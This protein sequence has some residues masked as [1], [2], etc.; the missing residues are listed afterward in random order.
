MADA[1]IRV[2]IE[3]LQSTLE[4]IAQLDQAVASIGTGS[5]GAGSMPISSEGTVSAT[6]PNIGATAPPPAPSQHATTIS[7]AATTAGTHQM[8]ATAGSVHAD[9]IDANSANPIP[10]TPSPA[11]PSS[12]PMLPR[13]PLPGETF[14]EWTQA[15]PSRVPL[16]NIYHSPT[17]PIID[18]DYDPASGTY[19]MA[20]SF[21][22]NASTV[23]GGVSGGGGAGGG[24]VAS[25]A[26]GSS[27]SKP[28]GIFNTGPFG[29]KD[30]GEGNLMSFLW[31]SYMVQGMMGQ[32]GGAYAQS[33]VSGV[34]YQSVQEG[35][36]MIGLGITGAGALLTTAM[37]LGPLP[38]MLGG[39]MI[40]SIVSSVM[41]PGADRDAQLANLYEVMGRNG[42]TG[43]YQP[44][45]TLPMIQEGSKL[46]QAGMPLTSQQM[47]DL[48]GTD[49]RGFWSGADHAFLKYT[50]LQWL[51]GMSDKDVDKSEQSDA[52][53]RWMYGTTTKGLFDSQYA[54]QDTDTM[55]KAYYGQTSRDIQGGRLVRTHK[56][57]MNSGD[58][59]NTAMILA[60]TDPQSALGLLATDNSA[61]KGQIDAVTKKG[62][63][64][65][66]A[67]FTGQM[68]Q[69][70]T[71]DLMAQMHMASY[72][73][74][75]EMTKVAP[76]LLSE[77]NSQASA[78]RAL[79]NAV[80][81]PLLK[82]QY[83][84]QAHILEMTANEQVYGQIFQEKS[85]E[86]SAFG[87]LNIDK[88]NISLQEQLHSGK[89]AY[90]TNWSAVSG[91]YEKQAGDTQALIQ[92]MA[93]KNLLSPAQR[94]IMQDQINQL[95][96]KAKIEVPIMKEDLERQELMAGVDLRRNQD[97]WAHSKELLYGSGMQQASGYD[98]ESK[99][100][101]DKKQ[102]LEE[103]LKTQKTLTFLQKEQLEST[104]AQ[105]KALQD[106]ADKESILAKQSAQRNVD[107]VN[108]DVASSKQQVA[109]LSGV[110]GREWA[111]LTM[112]TYQ[113]QT[114]Q[115]ATIQDQKND[116]L[117][118]TNMTGTNPKF[119]KFDKNSPEVEALEDKE[120]QEQ[121][122]IAQTKRSMAVP[123]MSGT[124]SAQ[125]SKE[126]TA[127]DIM[128]SGYG[129][130]AG[131]VRKA[132][133][134]EID[135]G[136]Q[137]IQEL[138]ANRSNLQGKGMWNNG[139]EADYQAEMHQET[140]KQL[141]LMQKYD[142]GWTDRLMSMT[143]NLP[144]SMS[145]LR[146]HFTHLDAARA[147]IDLPEF[148][149]TYAQN[150][151]HRAL[152]IRFLQT[153]Q[154]G[155]GE[156]FDLHGLAK[157]LNPYDTLHPASGTMGPIA[158]SVPG[159]ASGPGGPIGPKDGPVL[160]EKALAAQSRSQVQNYE[161]LV[162]EL[163]KSL[164]NLGVKVDITIKDDKGN[165]L[166]QTTQT[167][168]ANKTA[169]DVTTNQHANKRP[170][171]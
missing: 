77:I 119:K 19:G 41:Q 55:M 144:S 141:G 166:K 66:A 54:Q 98:L 7:T 122:N 86:L 20:G 76:Q 56:G 159:S 126:D 70:K 105:T 74:S 149:G 42:L 138:K 148:G 128:E 118:G 10:P 3:D 33:I 103:I 69:Y 49:S 152:P 132:I 68:A 154:S 163:V 109:Q 110:G 158:G 21:I 114:K 25:A 143:F 8:A 167:V 169:V 58:V 150:Q 162:A 1:K 52:L 140:D 107:T 29:Y 121:V 135:L 26:T 79:A 71:N 96:Y 82:Q 17:G 92:E 168:N 145:F 124:M 50:G 156:G 137:R 129:G 78:L 48:A 153:A 136:K 112:G 61:T 35:P 44:T 115:L 40:G 91:A 22:G 84:S 18:M 14:G 111:G 133:L 97:V 90:D 27:G 4:Q 34:P 146:A 53:G 39:S 108:T 64:I 9:A 46:L 75:G 24:G 67:Q 87:Q 38:G 113:A 28:G 5:T 88:S 60:D 131:A 31:S 116:L 59:F 85:D 102:K 94:A 81:D 125:Y 130:S 161:G 123:P 2:F 164:A 6:T 151:E 43:G 155:S 57:D 147:G 99:A 15:N 89:S 23:G 12:A 51:F 63:A 101:E 157:A 11:A 13:G 62:D 106:Q 83:N 93:A 100:L 104:L 95:R 160:N 134:N 80:S 72:G 45:L 120:A 127:L 30:G 73:G 37:G 65:G 171:G 170:S 139:M 36:S 142:E 16:P 117:N 47:A 165:V 32:L